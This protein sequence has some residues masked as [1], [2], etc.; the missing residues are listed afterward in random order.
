MNNTYLKQFCVAVSSDNELSKTSFI[1]L[2]EN[3]LTHFSPYLKA[4][5]QEN[6]LNLDSS[7]HSYYLDYVI[8][9]I[10]RTP[11]FNYTIDQFEKVLLQYDNSMKV[12]SFPYFSGSLSKDLNSLS[13]SLFYNALDDSN[14]ELIQQNAFAYASMLEAR[15]MIE[16]VENEKNKLSNTQSSFDKIKWNGKPSQLGFIIGMLTELDFIEA[17][18]RKTNDINYTQFAKQIKNIFEIDTTESTLSKYLNLDSEKGQ[19]TKRT[20]KKENFHIPNRKIVS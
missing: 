2:Y 18:K 9:Q 17:P 16:F 10:E 6:I 4:E 5:I 11:F 3:S 20:F 1:N 14:C 13:S 15:K 19:E 7:R 12:S 8:S